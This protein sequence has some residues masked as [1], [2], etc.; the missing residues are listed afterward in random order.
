MNQ[1]DRRRRR[2]FHP[3]AEACESR[4]LLS[5]VPLSAHPLYQPGSDHPIRPNTP[6]LPYAADFGVAT[7]IDPSVRIGAGKQITLNRQTYV[8]PYAS[9]DA[10]GGYIEI[11]KYVSILDNAA[12]VAGGGSA[13]GGLSGQHIGDQSVIAQ[14]AQVLG[15]ST[16]GVFGAEA[17]PTYV[18]PNA[19]IDNAV[20]APGS[21]VSAMAYVGPGVTIPTGMA[22]LPGAAVLT[23][24]EATDPALGKV[25][26][27]TRAQTITV[28]NALIAGV[29]LAKGYATVYQ[30]N[31]VTGVSPGTNTSGIYNGDL[32]QVLG[33]SP[34]AGKAV[35]PFENSSV[36]PQ[37]LAPRNRLVGAS[38]PQLRLRVIGNVVVTQRIGEVA[39]HSGR[40]DSIRADV[41]QPIKIGSIGSL[42]NGV[43]IHAPQG[44]KLTIGQNFVAQ[45]R[46]GDS[47][48]QERGDRR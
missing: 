10:N 3:E 21:Y 36:L 11:G 20:L 43:S 31:K 46:V 8:A 38:V 19:V 18:G 12:L 25:E 35:V 44:G 28:D 39:H 45:D 16:V 33:A 27:I 41:G 48:R 2:A 9:L 37:F 6:V 15:A 24:A 26:K 23:Q 13:A 42:G 17:L 29:A 47:R 7:F 14:G 5:A 32:S 40:S 34:D 22:V 1:T 4:Q 30:G